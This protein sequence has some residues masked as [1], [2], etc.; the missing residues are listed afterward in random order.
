M[1]N[2]QLNNAASQLAPGNDELAA[3]LAWQ[4]KAWP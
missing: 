3:W 1:I 2:Q 4:G